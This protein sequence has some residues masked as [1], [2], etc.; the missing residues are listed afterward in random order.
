M[1]QSN[2]KCFVI[3]LILMSGCGNN[4][5][6]NGNQNPSSDSSESCKLTKTQDEFNE[7]FKNTCESSTATDQA[8]L[9]YFR[10]LSSLKDDKTDELIPEFITLE[11]WTKHIKTLTKGDTECVKSILCG[12]KK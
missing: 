1:K 3:L 4:L 11:S 9:K 2:I 12:N 8:I 5:G 10:A 7:S 6:G